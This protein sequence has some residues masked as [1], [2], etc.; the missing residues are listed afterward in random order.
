[1]GCIVGEREEKMSIYLYVSSM[2]VSLMTLIATLITMNL[3]PDSRVTNYFGD[4]EICICLVISIALL[5]LGIYT[6]RKE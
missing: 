1:M 3:S 5:G 4:K 6:D 2:L